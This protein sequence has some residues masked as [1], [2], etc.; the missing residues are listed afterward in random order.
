MIN[1]T[2]LNGCIGPLFRAEQILVVGC[3]KRRWLPQRIAAVALLVAVF[4]THDSFAFDPTSQD[5]LI[6]ECRESISTLRNALRNV[7]IEGMYSGRIS[8]ERNPPGLA[9]GP[10]DKKPTAYRYILCGSREKLTVFR[11][12][13]EP[14]G[15]VVISNGDRSF[16]L[17]RNKTGQSHYVE[18][19]SLEAPYT[20]LLSDFR[21]DVVNACFTVA[22]FDLGEIIGTAGCTIGSVDSADKDGHSYKRIRFEYN[23]SSGKVVRLSGWVL[24]EPARQWSVTEYEV[25]RLFKAAKSKPESTSGHIVYTNAGDLP[26]PREIYQK[27][28]IENTNRSTRTLVFQVEDWRYQ[29]A[30]DSEFTLD[31][32]GLA[33]ALRPPGKRTRST[34]LWVWPVTLS[35]VSLGLALLIKRFGPR[36]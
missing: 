36:R 26:I 15:R 34:S 28:V 3:H 16:V 27:Q 5:R 7:R 22:G 30:P 14:F 13:P 20:K 32:Y 9:A 33:D 4:T 2:E 31:A 21:K 35:L 10:P 24:L 8:S 1:S 29:T 25:R 12:D 18:F 17:R 11:D 6:A 19:T 23:P